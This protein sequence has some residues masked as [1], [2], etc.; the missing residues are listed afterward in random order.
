[1]KKILYTGLD[2]S[3]YHSEGELIH[4]PLIQIVPRL[5]DDP[6]IQKSMKNFNQYTHVIITSK[7]TIPILINY[8]NLFNFTIVDWTSKV[9]VAVGGVTAQHLQKSGIS[10]NIV[11][12]EET[13]EGILNELD[14]LDLNG[15]YIFWPH[16]AQSRPIINQYFISKKLKFEHSTFY[17]TKPLEPAI[18]PNLKEFDEIIFT[19]PS[20]IQAFIQ[21]F[22][23][24]PADKI[25]TPIGPITE[26]Y[27]RQSNAKT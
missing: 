18:R 22:G 19:S 3:H 14:K 5:P 2:P 27:L 24:L 25:L 15:S 4:I 23:A 16:S 17:D 11:A 10:P 9:T 12:K 7:S 26:D 8:L 20:T 21:I 6:Q 13:A 1:M